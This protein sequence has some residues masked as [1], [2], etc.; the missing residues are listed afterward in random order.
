MIATV[1]PIDDLRQYG[2]RPGN[3]KRPPFGGRGIRHRSG[4]GSGGVADLGI[5]AKRLDGG[6]YLGQRV[7]SVTD[8]QRA[9]NEV[10]IK[11]GHTRHARQLA[12]NQCFLS[13]TVHLPDGQDRALRGTRLFRAHGLHA[14]G[15]QRLFD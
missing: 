5:E 8:R 9:L 7:R 10:E 12:P 6:Q 4:C 14:N 15:R 3:G 1:E 11:T 2:V 13:G